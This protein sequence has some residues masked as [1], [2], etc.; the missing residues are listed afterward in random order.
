MAVRSKLAESPP[1]RVVRGTKGELLRGLIRGDREA[2]TLAARELL[3]PIL[4]ASGLGRFV[5]IRGRHFRVRLFP[6]AASRCL[7]RDPASYLADEV[8]LF[9]ALL[10]PG[11]R[12]VDVGAN[13]GLLTMTASR[14]V[15]P[16][17]AVT[18]LEANPRTC[19]FLRANVHENRCAN[20]RVLNVA[21]ASRVGTLA[22]DTSDVDD[23][24]HH[25]GDTGEFVVPAMRL[26]DLLADAGGPI[27]LV[28]SDT[29]GYEVEVFR[30]ARGTLARTDAV[31]VESSDALLRRAGATLDDLLAELRASGFRL[32]AFQR[33]SLVPVSAARE[34]NSQNVLGLREGV[35]LPS[36][37]PPPPR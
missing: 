24:A 13:V 20:V 19:G 31:F 37:P 1:V 8:A 3:V 16:T 26:D 23:S 10:R 25:V 33:R 17:G 11:D 2:S 6:T 28:K 9:E 7:F 29:E 34:V 30:G 15:G 14:L 22:I 18:A 35:P 12:V 21:A 5:T 36:L 32:F 4:E 27:R